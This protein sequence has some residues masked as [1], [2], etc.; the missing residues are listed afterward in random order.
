MDGGVSPHHHTIF[1]SRLITLVT[2]DK[3]EVDLRTLRAIRVLRPLK[4]VSGV[5]SES[6]WR[7][8]VERVKLFLFRFTSGAQVN[9]QGAGSPHADRA[10]R[11]VR[12][13]HIRHHRPR[14]LLWSSPQDL[15]CPGQFG[16]VKLHTINDA[17]KLK[18]TLKWTLKSPQ[19]V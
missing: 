15:L 12:H 1:S 16:S 13:P 8:K 9:H 7:R 5:P 11:H 17:I 6:D 14:V 2:P 19:N 4:L 10:P 3:G 18:K